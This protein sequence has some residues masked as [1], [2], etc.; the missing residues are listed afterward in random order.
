MTSVFV[1]FRDAAQTAPPGVFAALL[2]FFALPA[3]F[4]AG[5]IAMLGMAALTRHVPKRY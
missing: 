3:V 4:V 5:G 2:H 1:T